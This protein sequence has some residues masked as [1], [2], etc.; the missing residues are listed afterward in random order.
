MLKIV[1]SRP[2][3]AKPF[4]EGRPGMTRPYRYRCSAGVATG[5]GLSAARRGEHV[6]A[7]VFI[8]E[9]LAEP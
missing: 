7:D 8:D 1:C 4:G 9:L 3:F 6:D 5:M 2:T